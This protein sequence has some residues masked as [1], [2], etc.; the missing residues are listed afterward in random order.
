MAKIN[1]V[2]TTRAMLSPAPWLPLA[3][4]RRDS[5]TSRVNASQDG[6][7]FRMRVTV[8][9]PGNPLIWRAFEGHRLPAYA[10]AYVSG[11]SHER[12]SHPSLQERPQPS[13]SYSA[14]AG[15][16]RERGH[17]SSRRQPS[18]Y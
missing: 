7:Q 4:A 8:G 18:D 2:G 17:Y 5:A 1:L 6:S 11:G 10:K 3:P 12:T 9:A 16:I 15:I 14:R 13:H